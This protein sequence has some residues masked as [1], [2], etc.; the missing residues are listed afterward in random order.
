MYHGELVLPQSSVSMAPSSSSAYLCR[1][2]VQCD[3]CDPPHEAPAARHQLWEQHQLCTGP[4]EPSSGQE[5]VCGLCPALPEG[6]W[7][8][9]PLGLAPPLSR[10][11]TLGLN[12]ARFRG[13]RFLSK[14]LRCLL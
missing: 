10:S 3:G 11:S 9:N 6:L 1:A 7:W 4:S 13:R 8:L 2:L 14:P 5:P 12:D